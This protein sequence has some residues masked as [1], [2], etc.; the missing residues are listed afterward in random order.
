MNHIVVTHN[1]THV[2]LYAN[3]EF[4]SQTTKTY[5]TNSQQAIM[6]GKNTNDRNDEYFNG[7]IDDV[8]ITRDEL[9][10]AEVQALYNGSNIELDNLL[11]SYDFNS[12]SGSTLVDQSGNGYNGSISGAAWV[13]SGGGGARVQD[14]FRA[15]KPGR[16]GGPLKLAALCHDID[17][18]PAAAVEGGGAGRT[19]CVGERRCV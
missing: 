13:E 18:I 8:I 14:N 15:N 10:L 17:S 19:L 16:G 9:G 11:A 1:G 2:K 5:N 12:G 6:I 7:T 3:G 4:I